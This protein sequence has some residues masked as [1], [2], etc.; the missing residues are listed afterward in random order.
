[1]LKVAEGYEETQKNHLD[2]SM[3][4]LSAMQGIYN[5]MFRKVY[6]FQRQL[7]P[8]TLPLTRMPYRPPR[9][10]NVHLFHLLTFYLLAR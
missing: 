2:M 8:R 4:V 10:L 3:V 9:I 1:M 6:I 5:T 7:L